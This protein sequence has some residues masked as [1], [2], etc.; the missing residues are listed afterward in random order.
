[1]AVSNQLRGP[2]P[3]G[4][5]KES[6]PANLGQ[7]RWSPPKSGLSTM[8]VESSIALKSKKISKLKMPANF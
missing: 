1:M 7:A 4:T 3:H 6:V 2:G 8:G 5:K